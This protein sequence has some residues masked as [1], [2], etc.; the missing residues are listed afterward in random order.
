ME[1]SYA[2]VRDELHR[3]DIVLY[4]LGYISM[5]SILRTYHHCTLFIVLSREMKVEEERIEA[6]KKR[7]LR[8]HLYFP[9]LPFGPY[10]I[11]VLQIVTKSEICN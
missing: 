1:C 4:F 2:L 8:Y 9:L 6:E 7:V 3:N 10:P 5:C 11:Y